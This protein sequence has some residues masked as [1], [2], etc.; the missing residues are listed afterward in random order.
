MFREKLNVGDAE[1]AHK[2]KGVFAFRLT[3][4][5]GEK[6]VRRLPLSGAGAQSDL[7]QYQILKRFYFKQLR[8]LPVTAGG[9]LHVVSNISSIS[10]KSPYPFE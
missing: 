9:A 6:A 3:C 5:T 4:E 2:V 7:H 1:H 10:G 8:I